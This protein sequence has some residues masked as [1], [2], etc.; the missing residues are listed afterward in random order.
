ME[1]RKVLPRSPIQVHLAT[2]GQLVKPSGA[3]SVVV[4]SLIKIRGD[5]PTVPLT[6]CP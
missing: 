6:S 4:Y 5:P 2:D 1:W 3:H